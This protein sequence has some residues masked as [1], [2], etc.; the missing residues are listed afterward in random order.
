MKLN[1][2]HRKEL[3]AQELIE[4]AEQ[5]KVPVRFIEV[6][7]VGAGKSYVGPSNEA[8]KTELEQWYGAC[9]RTW[10]KKET[11][12]GLCAVRKAVDARRLYQRDPR[13]V[14]RKLQPRTADKP[15]L[16]KALPLL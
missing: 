4:F 11:A 9:T 16:F 2:V 5:E 14:L 1:A 7:P 8:L 10:K 3:H 12:C 13:K 15:R 6:M